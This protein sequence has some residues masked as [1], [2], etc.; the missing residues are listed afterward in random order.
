[1]VNAVGEYVRGRLF[2]LTGNLNAGE[3]KGQL[4][5]LRRGIEIGRAHV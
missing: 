2:L 3:A 5:Q 1:M 4:A